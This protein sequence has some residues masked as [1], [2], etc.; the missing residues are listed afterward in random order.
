MSPDPHETKPAPEKSTDT[1]ESSER[2]GPLLANQTGEFLWLGIMFP[3]CIFTGAFLGWLV[4][5][6]L[7]TRFGLWAGLVF[8][9]MAAYY[10]LWQAIRG[11]SRSTL[12]DNAKDDTEPKP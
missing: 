2:K 5:H 12:S 7:G 3:A 4:D 11:G 9:I 8:G 10:N 1:P 6:F